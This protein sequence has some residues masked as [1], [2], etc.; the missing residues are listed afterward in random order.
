[1]NFIITKKMIS[2]II[3]VYN[4]A[5]FLVKCL[6]SVINQSY[7]DFEIIL[8]DDC[9]SDESIPIAQRFLDA[10]PEMSY[11]IVHHKRNRGLSAARN[12]GMTVAKGDYIFFLDSDDYLAHDCLG[13]MM[14]YMNQDERVE[15][16][17]GNY[18]LFG[19]ESGSPQLPDTGCYSSDS[20][21][22][23]QWASN[24]TIYVQAWNKLWRKSFL[25]KYAFSF[26]E[27]LNYE[28]VYW[29]FVTMCKVSR[30]AIVNITTYYYL[31]RSG[32][33]LRSDGEIKRAYHSCLIYNKLQEFVFENN[34]Q[35]KW[36][37]QMYIS[38]QFKYYI[39]FLL[40]NG[41]RKEAY[42]VYRQLR[43]NKM[44]DPLFLCRMN[45]TKHNLVASFHQYL[46]K[47][48]GFIWY[49]KFTR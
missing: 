17:V 36:H 13:N 6:D 43:N 30:L 38:S 28:D 33:I 8:V 9:G 23:T 45:E 11:E 22:F 31:V 26:P 2:V 4:V 24:H 15:L 29:S 25:D 42:E 14:E 41:K 49:D 20:C 34:L 12:T 48:L 19:N 39:K 47:S 32:S 37:I 18:S 35:D 5:P 7:K 3:P 44:W 46:P 21:D 40:Q 27:G 10:I 1:M 16:V